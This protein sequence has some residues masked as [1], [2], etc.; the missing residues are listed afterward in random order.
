MKV[1]G[2]GDARGW[3]LMASLIQWTWVWASSGSW[4][5]TGRPV[6]LKSM[7]SQRVRHD[8]ETELN[9]PVSWVRCEGAMLWVHFYDPFKEIFKIRVS[10]MH[11]PVSPQWLIL[12]W[13]LK[14]DVSCLLVICNRSIHHSL[15]DIVAK[16]AYA[17]WST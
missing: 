9:L 3:G 14:R 8:S 2:E 11:G 5:W 1:G 13:F 15:A 7:G 17:S 12:T 4:W 16:T 6:V 10:V